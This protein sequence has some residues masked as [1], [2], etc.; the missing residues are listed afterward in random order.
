MKRFVMM[1]ALVAVLMAGGAAGVYAAE[2]AVNETA[3]ITE[4]YHGYGGHWSGDGYRQSTPGYSH[5]G[6]RNRGNG[7]WHDGGG[8]YYHGDGHG[9]YG[10]H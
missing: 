9:W 7:G 1:G 8:N 10:H 6:N 4:N 5:W 2:Q 3:P